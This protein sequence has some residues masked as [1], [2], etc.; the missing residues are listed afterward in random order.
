MADAGLAD[1]SDVKIVDMFKE[2]WPD[3]HDGVFLSNIFHDW[4]EARC[5]LLAKRAFE[6]LPP[7][8]R[9]I[10]HE[11]LL[12]ETRDGPVPAASDSMHMMF[13]TEGKQ[14]SLGEFSSILGRAGFENVQATPTHGYYSVVTADKP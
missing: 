9:I 4:D 10:S 1:R 8:G 12:S 3:G 5:S 11:I 2:P 14:R 6:C 7:G 13:F